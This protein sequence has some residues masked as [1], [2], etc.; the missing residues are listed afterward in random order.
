MSKRRVSTTISIK[1]WELL[2]KYTEKYETQQKVLELALESLEKEKEKQSSVLSPE[3]QVWLRMRELNVVCL[4]HKDLFRELSRTADVERFDK[5]L[6][7]LRWAEYGVVVYNQKP[8]KECTLKEVMDGLVITIKAEKL[9][10]EIKYTDDGNYYTLRV[11]H[12]VVCCGIGY[13][14]SFKLFFEGLFEAYGAKTETKISENNL[15]MKIY[16]S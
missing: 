7:K 5:L 4:L 10:D 8:L 3:E 14:N 11:N 16:K 13:S 15:F 12:S 9:L 1:H 6:T 2:K